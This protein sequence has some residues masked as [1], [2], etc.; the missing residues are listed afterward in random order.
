MEKTNEKNFNEIKND[1]IGAEV[2]ITEGKYDRLG[3]LQYAESLAE[4]IK[5]CITPTTVAVQGE[6]GSGK[7]SMVNMVLESLEKEKC[8]CIKFSAWQYS[9]FAMEDSLQVTFLNRFL[10]ELQEFNGMQDEI[11][12]AL[13]I[14]KKV[15][16]SLAKKAAVYTANR[17]GGEELRDVA[18]EA[19]DTVVSVHEEDLI[20]QLRND[21][22]NVPFRNCVSNE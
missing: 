8:L 22:L 11:R 12:G 4:Y 1:N 2:P 13:D 6:W 5:T 3:L 15:T 16:V 7:T 21:I 10:N 14:V 18:V 17:I 19:I 9:Q 20:K